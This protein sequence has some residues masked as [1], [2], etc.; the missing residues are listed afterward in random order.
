MRTGTAVSHAI[1]FVTW[2]SL[3]REGSLTSDE[4]AD[5]MEA[6]VGAAAG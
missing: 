5:L 4:A 1:S 3:V 2:H 6:M